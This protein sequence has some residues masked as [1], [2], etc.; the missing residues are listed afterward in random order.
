MFTYGN[1]GRGGHKVDKRTGASPVQRLRKLELF[2]LE[3]RWFCG[4]LMET[5]QYLKG[6][7]GMPQRDS[8]SLLVV[9]GQGIMG[10]N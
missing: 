8:A 3:K 5:F 10:T 2:S 9:I 7:T 6:L 1:K 4:D